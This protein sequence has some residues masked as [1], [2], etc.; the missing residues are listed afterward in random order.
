MLHCTAHVRSLS[1]THTVRI[2]SYAIVI[3]Q[4]AELFVTEP[5]TFWISLSILLFQ[6]G[7][8]YTLRQ[9]DWWVLLL[10]AYAVGGTL[11]HSLQLAVHELSHDLCWSGKYKDTFNRLTAIMANLATAVPSAQTFK[12]YHMDHHQF[13]GV[14]GIDTDI[15]HE[16]E[17]NYVTNTISK[18]VWIIGE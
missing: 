4:I 11:N 1:H 18:I 3:T 17:L 15:P 13:Q 14:D 12:P 10:C 7:M 16:I 9:A 2:V 6:I 5:L 8:A